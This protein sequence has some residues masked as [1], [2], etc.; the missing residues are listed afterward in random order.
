M[1]VKKKVTAK[2][3]P[4]NLVSRC[5]ERTPDVFASTA[6]KSPRKTRYESQVPLS[7]WTEQ[8]PR[9]ERPGKDACSSSY[10][11]W[12]ADE[13]CSSQECKI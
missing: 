5:S 8:Q 4:M 7:S 6:S 11:E 12:N 1:Q 10:S 3:K 2:S 9:T 13:K